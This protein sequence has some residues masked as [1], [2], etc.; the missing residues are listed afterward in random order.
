LP[1]FFVTGQPGVGKTTIIIKVVDALRMRGLQVGGMTTREVREEGERVGFE[2]L[3]V[4]SG[5][6]G[7]LAHIDHLEG[8]KIGRYR[9]NRRDLEEV[10]VNALL[11]ALEDADLIVCD[12]IG[13]M[14]L[15]SQRFREAVEEIISSNTPVLGSLHIK[16]ADGSLPEL[17]RTSDTTI[18]LATQDNREALPLAITR[19]I[20]KWVE[21]NG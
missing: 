6:R 13:P 15:T 2:I 14:E 9:V 3:D 11:K 7:W 19:E 5:R 17:K 4:A 16:Y 20:L 8:V 21:R 1:S 12:E 10:G 18:Y